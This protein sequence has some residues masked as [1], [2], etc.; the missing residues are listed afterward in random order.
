MKP[1]IEGARHGLHE[2]VISGFFLVEMWRENGDNALELKE[3]S[4][5]LNIF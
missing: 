2:N 1:R 3:K 4:E 5:I